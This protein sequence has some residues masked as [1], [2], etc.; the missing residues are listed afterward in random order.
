MVQVRAR[1]G[2]GRILIEG[3]A[4]AISRIERLQRRLR[5]FNWLWGSLKEL[6]EAKEAVWFAS[7]GRG[8]WP[9]LSADYAAWKAKAF[10]GRPLMVLHGDLREQLTGPKAILAET[11]RQLVLGT[12]IP[13]AVY[14]LGGP[15]MPARPPL[16]TTTNL[17]AGL[18]R[19]VQL[20]LERV[21]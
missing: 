13:Y 2:E 9:P 1:I 6:F 21:I 19:R 20:E 3:D 5:Q 7:K 12:S 16:I 4:A 8:S 11:D 18:A 15:K 14:H 17:I 10:P